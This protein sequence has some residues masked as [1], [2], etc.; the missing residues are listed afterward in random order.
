MQASVEDSLGGQLTLTFSPGRTRLL[1]QGFDRTLAQ[2]RER[3]SS[4]TPGTVR[5]PLRPTFQ[6]VLS[7]SSSAPGPG[8]ASAVP[9]APPL[10]LAGPAPLA[11]SPIAALAAASQAPS[12]KLSREVRDIPSLWKEWTVGFAGL[13]SV[14]ELDRTWG[15]AWR[16]PSER[17]Y[18]STRRTIIDEIR[19]RAGD[20]EDYAGVVRG[21]KAERKASKASL[22]KVC[23]ALRQDRKGA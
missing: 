20:S 19:R 22:D 5:I 11:P 16:A 12:Y 2:Q 1:P 8:P 23:K 14:D 7:P 3:S 4:P 9:M 21:I 6:P 13:P 17:Q 15:S 10:T 18:Y